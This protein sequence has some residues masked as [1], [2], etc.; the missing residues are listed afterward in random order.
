M[1][2]QTPLND[3]LAIKQNVLQSRDEA[4]LMNWIDLIS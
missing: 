2:A 3:N 4:Y 1:A